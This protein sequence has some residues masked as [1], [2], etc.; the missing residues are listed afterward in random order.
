MTRIVVIAAIAACSKVAAEPC[1]RG[2]TVELRVVDN[3]SPYMRAL[4]RHV[5]SDRNEQPSDPAAISANIHASVDQWHHDVKTDSGL[6]IGSKT[7]TDYYL[8][9]QGRASLEAYVAALDKPPDDRELRFGPVAAGLDTPSTDWRTYYVKRE[10]MLDT[11]AIAQVDVATNPVTN[12]P[13]LLF[14]LTS[15]GAKA[16]A[17]GTRAATGKRVVTLI[18]GAVMGAPIIAE[19]IT[20]GRFSVNMPTRTAAEALFAKLSCTKK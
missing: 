1:E 5:G 7:E 15:D 6:W 17:N 20:H 12:G 14:E 9:G 16:F 10:A 13:V 19:P 4:F 3:D 11:R 2:A 8:A 18:D